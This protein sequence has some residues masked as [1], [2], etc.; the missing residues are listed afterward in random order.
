VGWGGG[1]G[2]GWAVSSGRGQPA[3]S[4]E[5]FFPSDRRRERNPGCSHELFS[6]PP[7]YGEPASRPAQGYAER[8]GHSTARRGSV[9]ALEPG[10][11]KVAWGIA[12][13]PVKTELGPGHLHTTWASYPGGICQEQIYP[14][15][16][17]NFM[18]TWPES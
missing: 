12:P 18:P 17:R 10:W 4:A 6:E 1:A 2:L 14:L 11:P 7:L 3:A 15:C 8:E 13:A 9:A 16:P 5:N